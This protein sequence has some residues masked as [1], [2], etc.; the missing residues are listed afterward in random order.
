MKICYDKFGHNTEVCAGLDSASHRASK[1]RARLMDQQRIGG[2]ASID[3]L[4]D[5][6]ELLIEAAEWS[7]GEKH[8]G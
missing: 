4:L 8:E 5:V 1:L 2:A 3:D 6:L 7:R